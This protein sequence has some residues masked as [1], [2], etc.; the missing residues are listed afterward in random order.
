[1]SAKLSDGPVSERDSVNAIP[2]LLVHARLS[3]VNIGSDLT[4]V[5]T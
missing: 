2:T 3:L 4:L 5:V 1:M